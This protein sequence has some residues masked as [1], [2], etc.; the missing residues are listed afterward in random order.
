MKKLAIAV[1]VCTAALFGQEFK[2]GTHVGDFTV[3]D[4]QGSPVQFSALKGEVTVV[5][6]I[7]T[8][9]PVSNAY[10]ERMKALYNDYAPKGV[11]F[12]FVNANRGETA[13]DV[14]QHAQ[15]HG[16]PFAVYKDEN[17]VVADRFG[18]TVTPESF[19]IESSGTIRYHG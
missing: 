9:C 13:A 16:F 3:A 10:N 2:L 18:A 15:Q 6:F 1:C 11:K 14:A 19:V 17:N 4:V 7:S 12:V 8:Q 5:T